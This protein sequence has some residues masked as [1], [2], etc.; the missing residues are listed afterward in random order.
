MRQVLA[1]YSDL[2]VSQ[3]THRGAGAPLFFLNPALLN[4]RARLKIRVWEI[5]LSS[6]LAPGFL[7]FNSLIA[8]GK[9]GLQ[10]RS[11]RRWIVLANKSHWV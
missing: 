11:V 2:L 9:N 4:R 6:G 8:L 3:W 10:L 7:L 5:F 1:N